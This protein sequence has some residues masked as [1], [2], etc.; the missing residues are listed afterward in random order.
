MADGHLAVLDL[1]TRETTRLDLAGVSPTYVATGHLVYAAAD[2]SM[3]AVPF[4]PT[5]AEVRGSSV[6]LIEGVVVKG[7]GADYSVSDDGRLVYVLDT[8]DRATRRSLVWVDRDGQEEPIAAPFRDYTYPRVSPD[9]KQI[10][11]D[12]RDEEDDL[13]V[14]DR[15]LTRLTFDPSND[16]YGHWMPDGQHVVFGSGRGGVTN[17]YRKAA[18]GTG[19]AEPVTQ[20]EHHLRLNAVTPDGTHVVAAAI[21]PN[22]QN[23][24]VVAALDGDHATEMLIGTEFDERNAAMSPDGAWVAFESNESGQYEVYVRPFSD[25]EAGRWQVS[26]DGGQDALWALDGREIFYWT[27]SGLMAASVQTE[28]SFGH[29]TPQLLFEGRY[30]QAVGRTYDV[31]PDGRFVMVKEVVEDEAP[32]PVIVVVDNWFQELTERVPVN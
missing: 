10:L 1:G 6:P 14:W 26:T 29:G 22:R 2:G 18:D 27:E 13:W 30:H 8:G 31:A 15:T 11:L 24:L 12:L 20:S 28:P 25:V 17:I 16:E 4:D 21:V 19:T 9:G 23:D 32:P 7:G 5:S 3:R